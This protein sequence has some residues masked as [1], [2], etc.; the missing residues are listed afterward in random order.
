[1]ADERRPTVALPETRQLDVLAN[2]LLKRGVDV[3]RCPMIAIKDAPDRDKITAWI[4]RFCDRRMQLLVVYTGE[5][6]ERLT[7]FAERAGLKDRFVATLESTPLLTR[8][9][10]PA[11]ALRR[12]GIKPTYPADLAT[13]DG[14]IETL[15]DIEIAGKCI[16]I[17]L[18][19]GEPLPKLTGYLDTRGARADC[20]APYVYASESDDAAVE[21]LIS[22]I[23]AREIDAIA[24]TSKSQVQRLAR[25][26]ERVAAGSLARLLG[27]IVVAAV[28]PVAAAE[29][30]DSGVTVDVQ[31]VSEFF[32]KPMVTALM[33]HMEASTTKPGA[34][35]VS[36]DGV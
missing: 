23:A 34:D 2:L 15:A 7:G 27:P 16:G 20:V 13:T 35:P 28:G 12:F 26:A 19:G 31:P 3:V 29:L 14:I 1:M 36:G 4:K 21:A 18:Y 32:M 11:R 33:A 17:Q 5:G 22:S 9:P 10:K 24:F 25:V 6:I 30:T 8:G